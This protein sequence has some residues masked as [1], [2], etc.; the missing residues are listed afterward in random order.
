MVD[1]NE[2]DNDSEALRTA[3]NIGLGEL[4]YSK[5]YADNHDTQLRAWAR[6]FADAFGLLGLMWIGVTMFLPVG[7]RIYAAA[8]F[9]ASVACIALDRGL[10]AVEP[11]VSRR[12]ST[13]ATT[14]LGGEKA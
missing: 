10:A 5:G 8:P 11:Q 13:I 2:A 3:L 1:D 14:L 12:L 9:A 7:L 4:G 6:R